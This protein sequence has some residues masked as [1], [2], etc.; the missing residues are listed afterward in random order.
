[1]SV[2]KIFSIFQKIESAESFTDQLRDSISTDLIQYKNKNPDNIND[3]YAIADFLGRICEQT[4]K[5][6]EDD[7]VFRIDK[8][9]DSLTSFNQRIDINYDRVWQYEGDPTYFLE[10]QAKKN[11][12]VKLSRIESGLKKEC[13]QAL[14]DQQAPRLP[15]IAQRKVEVVPFNS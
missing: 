1:M 9:K 12:D 7:V 15:Y 8:T 11:Q 14:N 10:L 6:L 4:K 2:A 3:L 13:E 5:V